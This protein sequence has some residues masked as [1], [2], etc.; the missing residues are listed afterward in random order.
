MFY[1]IN[2]HTLM[3][4]LSKLDQVFISCYEV[5]ELTMLQISGY[6]CQATDIT[7]GVALRN[8][9]LLLEFQ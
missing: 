7:I 6:I 2:H 9:S 3:M 1:Y 4:K 5:K 8:I